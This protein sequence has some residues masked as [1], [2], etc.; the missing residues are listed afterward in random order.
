MTKLK[1]GKNSKIKVMHVLSKLDTGGLE[2]G[3]INLCNNLDRERFEPA[4]C[5]LNGFGS[6]AQR[7]RA[8]VKLFNLNLPD[9]RNLLYSLKLA[10]FYRRE[11]PDIVHAH[12]WGQCSLYAVTGARIAGVPVVVNG[13]HGA[14]F[15][16]R[17]QIFL[18]KITALLST[19]LLSVSESLKGK[20]AEELGIPALKIKVIHNGVDTQIFTGGYDVSG[21]KEELIK[22]F[23][24]HIGAKTLVIGS[25]GSLKRQKNQIILLEALKALNMENPD[26]NIKVIFVGDGP[27]KLMLEKYVTDNNMKGQAVF[28]GERNDIPRL[29][30]LFDIFVSTSLSEGFS[31]VILEA[32]SSAVPV[33]A[34]KSVGTPE[35]VYDGT[36][37]F[38][39]YPPVE[40]AGF[41]EKIKSLADDPRL[42][43]ELSANARRLTEENF[44]IKSM[45]S[46]YEKLYSDSLN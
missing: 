4:I 17:R 37:G 44:S 38:I 5:C 41:A 39:V 29:L 25:V 35:L 46:S 8:D 26:N 45:V 13:E 20:V 2:N 21:L 3:I 32:T 14:V 22:K 30:S 19:T 11:K 9:E 33:I 36:N 23:N 12:G 18:Q 1:D 42:L 40:A 15:T 6:M 16:R 27:D 28:L 31:N 24:F 7:L 43:K 10:G 34:T